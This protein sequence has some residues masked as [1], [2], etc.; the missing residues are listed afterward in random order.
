[1]KLKS[2]FCRGNIGICGTSLLEGDIEFVRS[3]GDGVVCADAVSEY[4]PPSECV[5]FV[6]P[7]GW[8]SRA[9]AVAAAASSTV[10]V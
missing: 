5:R 9:A 7:E 8:E 3:P 6:R 1:M 4:I 10:P 2:L